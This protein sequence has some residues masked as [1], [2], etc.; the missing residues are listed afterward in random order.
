MDRALLAASCDHVLRQAVAMHAQYELVTAQRRQTQ[1]RVQGLRA[2]LDL[3]GQAVAVLRQLGAAGRDRLKRTLEPLAAQGL[4]EI[5]GE[6]ARFEIVFKPLPKSGFSAQIVTGVGA[7]RG[8]PVNTDG[9]SV[10]QI[11]SDG[12]LRTLITCLH[13]QGVNRIIA[14]DE[15]FAGVDKANLRPLF[16]LLRGLSEE[17]GVQFIMVTHLDDEAVS[18]LVDKT[19][20]LDRPTEMV[21]VEAL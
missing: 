20:R 2:T 16:Q 14:L 1:D 15:P 9:D 21:A 7:Q 8:N 17:M 6:D 13:R 11:L 12:V 5:F 18:D 3:A 4:R 19:V 10:A